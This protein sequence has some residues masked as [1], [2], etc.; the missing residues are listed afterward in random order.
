MSSRLGLGMIG[1]LSGTAKWLS[2]WLLRVFYII[3]REVSATWLFIENTAK[4]P[5]CSINQT[6][7]FFNFQ[8][9]Q[10]Q[11]QHMLCLTQPA[12]NSEG[13]CREPDPFV[14][15][16]V[17]STPFRYAKYAYACNA[18]HIKMHKKQ[19]LSHQVVSLSDFPLSECCLS[20]NKWHR[21]ADNILAEGF[22]CVIVFL[23]DR[24]HYEV[25]HLGAIAL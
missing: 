4:S 8:A 15:N 2:D 21:N 1:A 18:F 25:T 24:Y 17:Q 22:C 6:S 23:T 9:A 13:N 19:K 10:W 14:I 11:V 3:S 20:G 16:A 12:Y 5:R 7:R